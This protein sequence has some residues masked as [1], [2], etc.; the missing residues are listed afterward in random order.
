MRNRVEKDAVRWR[1]WWIRV[2]PVRGFPGGRRSIGYRV[3]ILGGRWLAGLVCLGGVACPS[4]G[5]QVCTGVQLV[6][7]APKP[8]GALG[9]R[10]TSAGYGPTTGASVSAQPL[11]SRTKAWWS[12]RDMTT[13]RWCSIAAGCWSRWALPALLTLRSTPRCRASRSSRCSL[14][15]GPAS[16]TMVPLN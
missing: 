13:S 5:C 9:G 8:H 2:I 4:R 16:V 6:D 15:R 12:P 14:C 1:H 10:Q 7:P 3:P 11:E